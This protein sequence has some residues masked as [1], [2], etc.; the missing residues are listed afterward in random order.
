MHLYAQLHRVFILACL[1]FNGGFVQL[2]GG[3]TIISWAN[4]TNAMGAN[5][6]TFV[7]QDTNRHDIDRVLH[8]VPY[9][10]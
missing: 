5:V 3:K 6:L 8:M 1:H 2:P 9:P 10:T 7:S 4:K